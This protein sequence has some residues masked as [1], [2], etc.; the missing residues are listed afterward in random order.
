M[1]KRLGMHK[2]RSIDD[3]AKDQKRRTEER[4]MLPSDAQ[5]YCAN[6]GKL[7]GSKKTNISFPERPCLGCGSTETRVRYR[8]GY[9]ISR[10]RWLELENARMQKEDFERMREAGR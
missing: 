9:E 8:N 1:W 7:K 5:P 4:K 3:I 2:E 10:E 6:C